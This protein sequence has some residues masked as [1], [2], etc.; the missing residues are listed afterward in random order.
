MQD[1]SMSKASY[2]D[3]RQADDNEYPPYTDDAQYF[4]IYIS[5]PFSPRDTI[6]TLIPVSSSV[7]ADSE[8]ESELDLSLCL[9][10]PP[11]RIQCLFDQ[12]QLLPL[13]LIP[14]PL[15]YDMDLKD[16]HASSDSSSSGPARVKTHFP[17]LLKTATK[18]KISLFRFRKWGKLVMDLL[19]PC[20]EGGISMQ[21]KL[22]NNDMSSEGIMRLMELHRA[23]QV[24][25][26]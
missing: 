8:D 6:P 17:K 4:D 22:P 13:Q 10:N 2:S 7:D 23:I 18:V 1:Y 21:Q 3:D 24:L 19:S 9:A 20:A 5:L 25:E 26:C 15:E 12:G 14:M 11:T 16:I